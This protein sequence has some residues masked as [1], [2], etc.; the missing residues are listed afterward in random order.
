MNKVLILNLMNKLNK[1]NQ[2]KTIYNIIKSNNK[3]TVKLHLP[4]RISLHNLQLQNLSKIYNIIIKVVI[5]Q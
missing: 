2:I 5:L 3:I 4:H 1:P